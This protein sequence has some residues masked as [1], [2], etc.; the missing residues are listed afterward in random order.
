MVRF[1][2]RTFPSHSPL[3]A[4]TMTSAKKPPSDQR[5]DQA[6]E[7]RRRGGTW[8]V[9]AQRL[10]CSAETVRKWPLY[11]PMRWQAAIRRTRAKLADAA[12]GEVTHVLR[13]LLED[14]DCKVRWH[15]ARALVGMRLDRMR[16]EI[17]G[18]TSPRP[19]AAN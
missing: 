16:R 5:L 2:R 1:C 6:V 15:A 10:N 4:H 3:G 19:R 7:L 17:V 13:M 11:Y 18:R 9:V 8:E 12:D 14:D